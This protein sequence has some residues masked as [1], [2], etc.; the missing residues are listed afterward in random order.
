MARHFD[1]DLNLLK[2][3]LA[4]MAGFAMSNIY[5]SV[6]TLVER[7]D[8]KVAQINTQEQR[9]NS[10]QIEID[11]FCLELIALHQPVAADLRLLASAMKINAELERIADQTINLTQAALQLIRQP[12]LKP[13]IDIPKMADMVQRM[14]KDALD[15]F[16]QKD[17]Q[18]A[19]DVLK[20][21]DEVDELKNRCYEEL[22][23][24][25]SQEK[26]S[27]PR[28]MQLIFVSRNLERIADLA[29]NIAEDVIYLVE[30]KDVRH[31]SEST[32]H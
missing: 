5:L 10:L 9:V 22:L 26:E 24:L 8:E 15:G 27:I 19:R 4:L 21:D 14:V 29:T 7:N 32:Q 6:K 1:K 30:G 16:V 3:K 18:L 17:S 31:H 20:R 2:E 23:N 28:G 12:Q 13:L 25:M 11:N